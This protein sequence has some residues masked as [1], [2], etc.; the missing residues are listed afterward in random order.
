MK[1]K[2]L[3]YIE[4]CYQTRDKFKF[5]RVNELCQVFD[6]DRNEIINILHELEN[7]GNLIRSGSNYSLPEKPIKNKNIN[8]SFLILFIIIIGII[9]SFLS[10]YNSF[11][12]FKTNTNL[13]MAFVN[14]ITI[15]LIT[16][17][18]LQ[19][20]LLFKKILRFL[21]IFI[22][23]ISLFFNMFTTIGGQLQLEQEKQNKNQINNFKNIK[24]KKLYENYKDQ[25]NEIKIDLQ[26]ERKEREKLFEF[27]EK[28]KYLSKEY[29]DI[30]YRIALKNNDIEYFKKQIN[31]LQQKIDSLL[32]NFIY[33]K[34]KITYYEWLKK[35]LNIEEHYFQFLIKFLFAIFVDI[36]S[37][38][39]FGVV[40]SYKK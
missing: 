37:P 29:K 22:W 1:N 33:T 4:N 35:I 32:N 16:I 11:I 26:A 34:E 39:S 7:E 2:I 21:F 31:K 23:F 36:I 18:L 12:F 3:D 14:S 13:F 19:M 5:P 24:D 38:I 40:F 6:L 9:T 30:N 8:F 10:V 20:A 27:L 25:I 17:G 15:I 28:S